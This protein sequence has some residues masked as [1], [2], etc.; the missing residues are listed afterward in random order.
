ML[1]PFFLPPAAA[2]DA[3]SAIA[4]ADCSTA[5][6]ASPIGSTICPAHRRRSAEPAATLEAE[7]RAAGGRRSRSVL[8]AAQHRQERLLRD[9]D[10]ADLAHALLA[11]LL[12]LEQLALARDVAAVAL[13][14]HV[15]AH[16]RD[17]LARDDLA[18][19]RGLQRDLELVARDLAAQR[20]QDLA[21]ATLGLVLVAQERQ[22][23]DLVAGDQDAHL[24]EVARL[25]ALEL[26]V[27]RAVA[28]R[29]RLQ[30]VV[31][32]EDDL[33]ER[34]PEADHH[35]LAA[36]VVGLHVLAAP[37]GAQLHDGADVLGRHDD[38]HARDRLEVVEDQR[39]V[40]QF[41]RRADLLLLAAVQLD[42][43]AH[44]RRRLHEVHVLL[45]LEPLLDHFHVQQ[46]EEAA[47]EAEA[48]RIAGLGLERE[49]AVVEP[50]LLERLAQ[51]LELARIGRVEAAE[52]HRLGLPEA[53]QLRAAEV[54]VLVRDGVADDDVLQLLDVGEDVTD[55]AGRQFV[56]GLHV[57]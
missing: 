18:A 51:V 9:L 36:V 23:V 28:A 27:H 37:V 52:H 21:A 33:R 20:L 17:A 53:R 41:A 1:G 40:G 5:V 11:F 26:V 42:A 57:G 54:L 10:A 12:L 43:V 14:G 15:L 47:A 16:R 35:A 13:R 3:D 29:H 49:R 7:T 6:R 8:A 22:R 48:E 4:N 44:G 2:A 45:A 32:V 34:D 50:H 30:P 46:A 39:A 38:V 24:D 55:L 31:E 19:D 56:D 25:E